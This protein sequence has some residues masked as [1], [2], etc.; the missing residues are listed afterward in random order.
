MIG[1]VIEMLA[2]RKQM[3][4]LVG[5]CVLGIAAVATSASMAHGYNDLGAARGVTV[6]IAI[7]VSLL[8]LILAHYM[9]GFVARR[10]ERMVA[11]LKAMSEGDLAQT[12]SISGRD[13]FAWMAWEDSCARKEFANMGNE[14]LAHSRQ[15]AAAA[16]VQAGDY[17]TSTGEHGLATGFGDAAPVAVGRI[18][19]S[20]GLGVLVRKY[21]LSI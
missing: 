9:G 16:G 6:G 21:L 18:T 10:A 11:A 7:S 2:I 14:I 17:T 20:G 12:V 13:E 1:K 4:L 15:L 5:V 3:Y 19:L 8:L